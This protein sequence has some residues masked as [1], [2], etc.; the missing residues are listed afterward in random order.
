[1][2]AKVNV[3]YIYSSTS[4][5][6]WQGAVQDVKYKIRAMRGQREEEIKEC[7]CETMRAQILAH[8]QRLWRVS[9]CHKE[10][11]TQEAGGHVN[12]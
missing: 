11:A 7:A 2:T 10:E 12:N 3:V 4:M 9:V 1:M 6:R 5:R 8:G